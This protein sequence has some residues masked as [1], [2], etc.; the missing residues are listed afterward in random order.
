M[1]PVCGGVCQ[2]RMQGVSCSG[3]SCPVLFILLVSILPVFLKR[4]V[5]TAATT[6]KGQE[7]R[8][9]VIGYHSNLITWSDGNSLPHAIVPSL[10]GKT[11]AEAERAK[12]RLCAQSHLILCDPMDCSLPGSSGHRILQARILEWVA[13][14]FSRGSS[15]PGD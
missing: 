10:G 11:M 15:R 12:W 5:F 14:T 8:W 13:I 1:H 7:N 3:C 6:G 9:I 2:G 4:E